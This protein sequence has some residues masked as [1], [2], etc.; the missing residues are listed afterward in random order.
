MQ[1]KQKELEEENRLLFDQ[2]TVLQEALE[3]MHH[4]GKPT[5]QQAD[6]EVIKLKLL[7]EMV[8]LQEEISRDTAL[9]K[10]QREVHK[11]E[12]EK[13]LP[14][15]LGKVLIE[16]IASPGA[17]L[18]LPGRLFKIWRK[19]SQSRAPKSLGGNG[20]GKVIEAY[21]TGG[22]QSVE[23]LLSYADISPNLQA[24]AWTAVAR[25][26]Q[27]RAPQQAAEAARR[28]FSEDPRAFRLKWLGFRLYEAGELVEAEA[29][30]TLLP[31]DI[32]FSESE[33]RQLK[34]LRQEAGYL[35]FT[36]AKMKVG[37][38]QGRLQVEQKM[39][40]TSRD[41]RPLAAKNKFYKSR[42]KK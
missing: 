1:N 20:Y 15:R 38:D 25:H 24:N 2:L 8:M 9:L 41:K 13:S 37:F 42:K 3:R 26:L 14:Y 29:V 21:R 6:F 28:A 35:R 33:T 7:D 31:A 30:M 22:I 39:E 27:M 16:G 12:H 5:E 10:V 4:S 17:L 40:D 11:L 19:F 18:V 34:A 23:Q 32:T 36:Q